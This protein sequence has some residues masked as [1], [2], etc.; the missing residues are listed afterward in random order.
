MR[1]YWVFILTNVLAKMNNLD[2]KKTENSR[3]N[4]CRAKTIKNKTNTI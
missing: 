2:I 1:F 3:V 4:Y